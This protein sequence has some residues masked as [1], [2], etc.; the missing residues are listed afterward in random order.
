MLPIFGAGIKGGRVIGGYDKSAA[1]TP[2]G[3]TF[4]SAQLAATMLHALGV[5]FRTYVAADPIDQVFA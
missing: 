3:P 4:S 2:T 1:L 5:D